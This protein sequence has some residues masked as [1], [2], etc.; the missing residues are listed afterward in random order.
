M[1]FT[2][3]RAYRALALAVPV[4]LAVILSLACSSQEPPKPAETK[5]VEPAQAITV[6]QPNPEKTTETSEGQ[7]DYSIEALIRN[8]P[9]DI[10]LMEPYKVTGY[11]PEYGGFRQITINLNAPMDDVYNYY[12]DNLFIKNGWEP[13]ESS[14]AGVPDIFLSFKCRKD[15]REL[16]V[17]LK[18][19]QEGKETLVQLGLTD[20]TKHK[21]KSE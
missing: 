4:T 20:L 15:V 8:W 11:L 19:E 9:E 10:P 13:V 12:A 14:K 16:D 18:S 5:P 3:G 1:I 2:R 21:K 17:M 7:S 6:P